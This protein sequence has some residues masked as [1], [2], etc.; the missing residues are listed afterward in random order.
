MSQMKTDE[1]EDELSAE[2]PQTTSSKT[3]HGRRCSSAVRLFDARLSDKDTVT[4]EAKSEAHS[5]IFGPMRESDDFRVSLEVWTLE[6]S[7]VVLMNESVFCC[8]AS[9]LI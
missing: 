1:Q 8:E 7:C 9:G 5:A 4:S 2:Q 6:V 3:T